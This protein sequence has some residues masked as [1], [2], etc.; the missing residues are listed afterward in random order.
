V[1]GPFY[2]IQFQAA[3]EQLAI[4]QITAQ[5]IFEDSDFDFTRPEF[6]WEILGTLVFPKGGQ[7]GIPIIDGDIS[8]RDFLKDMVKLLL[9]G[10]TAPV[11]KGGIELLTDADIEVLEKF[12]FSRDPNSAWGFDDQFSMEINVSVNNGTEFPT[13]PFILQNNVVLVL[14]ALKPAHTLFD[15]RH[16]F[17]EFFG[18]ILQAEF[19]MEIES[20][21][22][23]D[24][25]KL[26]FGAKSI[27]SD[28][29]ETLLDRICFRDTTRDFTSIP[30]NAILTI[31]SGPNF[32]SY[33]VVSKQTWLFGDDSIARAYTTN[34]TGLSGSLTVSGDN[35]IDPDQNWALAVENEILTIAAGP[36]AGTYRLKTI[37]GSNGGPVGFAVGPSTMVRI[38]Q[39]ILKVERRMPEVATGQSYNV[40]V[41]RLGVRVPQTVIGEDASSFFLL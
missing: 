27:T 1:T 37:L 4:I 33:C 7:T 5:E 2:S 39:S 35:A 25:R 34:P 12:L 36:N 18:D 24:T 17:K 30:I 20:Y 14:D 22:Y 41:D 15:Y 21:Y 11:V 3:A 23:D 9:R 8:Y 10:A 38:S 29:G 28:V 32:E 31:E 16:L 40:T 19:S 13:E 26:C 6:L